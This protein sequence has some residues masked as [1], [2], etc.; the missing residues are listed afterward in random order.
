MLGK[1]IVGEI[2]HDAS[3]LT[4]PSWVP[5]GPKHPGS[6]KQGKL[7]ADQW[8]SFCTINLVVT[9]VRL[10]GL[11]P[12]DSEKGRMLENFLHLVSAIKYAT[13][14]SITEESIVAYEMHLQ[15]YLRTLLDL[16]PGTELVA[17]QHMA[18]HFGDHLR[19]FGPTHS[20]RCFAFERFNFLLQK[21][22][23]NNVPGSSF[24]I[25]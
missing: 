13:L 12:P 17:N 6:T 4:L 23:T 16:Y 3:R 14:R 15:A 11:D 9:L 20:W 1:K 2:K 19:R 7:H 18:L 10:W 24:I 25:L 8:R 22:G 21:V 5:N